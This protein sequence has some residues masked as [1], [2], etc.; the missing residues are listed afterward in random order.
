[1]LSFRAMSNRGFD[2]STPQFGTAEYL[3]SPAVDHCHFCQQPIAGSYYRINGE[4]ACRACAQ[5]AQT[6]LPTESHAAYVRGVL[7]GVGFCTPR[8]RS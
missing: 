8:S 6:E 4:M 1:M 2:N 7:F 5:K 3:G